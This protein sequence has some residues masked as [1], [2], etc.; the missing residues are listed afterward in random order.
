MAD[1]ADGAHLVGFD[2]NKVS[3]IEAE[4]GSIDIGYL[5]TQTGGTLTKVE[6]GTGVLFTETLTATGGKVTTSHK[7][8]GV[9]GNEI[10]YVYPLDE[11]SDPDRMNAYVQGASASTTEFA[12]N[13]ATKEITLPTGK[14]EDGVKIYVVVLPYFQFL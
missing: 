10:G 4:N 9:A 1:G 12:Y 2:T 11:T 3:T 8:S 13:P 14:F 6:N 7:A 5:E